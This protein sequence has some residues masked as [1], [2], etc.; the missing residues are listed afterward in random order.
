LSEVAGHFLFATLCGSEQFHI[1][2][3]ERVL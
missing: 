3:R 1:H 2:L